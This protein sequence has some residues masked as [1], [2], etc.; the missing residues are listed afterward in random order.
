MLTL[1]D[2][3]TSLDLNR[4]TSPD[5]PPV[6]QIR[7][8]L[9]AAL[10]NARLAP[11]AFLPSETEIAA[12]LELARTTVNR[13][14]AATPEVVESVDGRGWRVRDYAEFAAVMLLDGGRRLTAVPHFRSKEAATTW[15]RRIEG[16]HRA[17]ITF[18]Y[19]IPLVAASQVVAAVAQ[20]T[21]PGG[22]ENIDTQGEERTT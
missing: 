15:G 11:G 9:L 10:D 14:L 6:K 12:R 7:E 20:P 2:F 16:E 21:M 3:P 4:R 17:N 8:F 18:A 5:N 13:A 19:A 22:N 1:D